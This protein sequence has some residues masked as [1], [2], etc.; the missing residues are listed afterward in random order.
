MNCNQLDPAL[1]FEPI[2]NLEEERAKSSL[3]QEKIRKLK[4]R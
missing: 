4:Y 1:I 3:E 2:E